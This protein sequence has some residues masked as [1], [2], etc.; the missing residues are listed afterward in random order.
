MRIALLSD[1]HSNS[2]ALEAVLFEIDS[3]AV[4]SIYCLGDIVGYGAD[5]GD[6]LEIIKSRCA[7][8]VLGNHDLAVATG[9]GLE[10][11]PPNGQAAARHNREASEVSWSRTLEFFT[12]HLKGADAR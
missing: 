5:P 3:R 2:Q 10:V 11:L 7:G 1:I 8:V 9:H 4:D 6:C 12:T